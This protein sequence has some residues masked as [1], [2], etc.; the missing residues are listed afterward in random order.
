MVRINKIYTKNGDKGETQ[1]VGGKPVQKDDVR[2]HSYGEID[3]LNV[4]IA[5]IIEHLK[6]A[7]ENGND[8][9]RAEQFQEMSLF[10]TGL[11]NTLFDLGAEIATPP[12]SEWQPKNLL[13]AALV[14]DLEQRIDTMVEAVPPL[15]SFVLPG[16]NLLNTQIHRARTVCRRAERS[17]ITLHQGEPVRGE[18]LQFVNR[19]SDYLFAASRW[20][21]MVLGVPEQ[22]W[23]PGGI[24]EKESGD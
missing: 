12:D 21:N 17:L 23:V 18:V 5:A 16:G 4:E 22:L 6:L 24:G 19:L 20:V 9:K 7:C 8:P 11:Q 1:L 3:E 14:K 15:T 10:L 2:V 13:P